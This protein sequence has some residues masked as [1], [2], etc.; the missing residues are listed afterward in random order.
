MA[1][2]AAG[3]YADPN[4]GSGQGYWDG[5]DWTQSTT[6][7]DAQAVPQPSVSHTLAASRALARE[8]S[9]RPS[10]PR[11]ST[12]CSCRARLEALGS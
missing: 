2:V 3:W 8:N 9:A 11:S 6:A 7:T 12:S 4:G 5:T 10:G 1:E